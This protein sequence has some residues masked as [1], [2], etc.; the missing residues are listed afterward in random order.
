MMTIRR[1]IDITADRK[2]RFDVAL[3]E[4]VPCG[5][6]RVVL[7]FPFTTRGNDSEV[8][9]PEMEEALR[10]GEEKLRY[11]K[12][13]PEELREAL[14]KFQEGSPLF[15]GIGADEFARRRRDEWA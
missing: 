2:A 14:G 15:G 13:H 8:L 6:S 4:T 12:S 10:E 7:H 5:K 11:Y 3:P 9:S 1:T